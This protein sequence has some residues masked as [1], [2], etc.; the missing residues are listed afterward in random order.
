MPSSLSLI[1]LAFDLKWETQ[2]SSK[3]V[4]SFPNIGTLWLHS[5]TVWRN[6]YGYD[7]VV[8]I[9]KTSPGDCNVQ[10]SLEVTD[11]ALICFFLGHIACEQGRTWKRI[12]C[13][14][15]QC[16]FHCSNIVFLLN[17]IAPNDSKGKN[18]ITA[19]DF[20][21]VWSILNAC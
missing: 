19:W 3:V 1:I 21:E 18:Q 16:T 17:E 5:Q 12:I 8:G 2:N 7:L 9:L 11:L 14:Q 6:W 10:Q 15:G 13:Y 20:I 4:P